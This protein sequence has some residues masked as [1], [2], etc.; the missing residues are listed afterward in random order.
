MLKKLLFG[1]LLS[2]LLVSCIDNNDTPPKD[3][4]A[5]LTAKLWTFNRFEI[6]ELNEN[7]GKYTEAEVEAIINKLRKGI[8]FKF[9]EDT[10]GTYTVRSESFD[11]NWSLEEGILKLRFSDSMLN[12]DFRLNDV[13]EEELN[14]SF[15]TLSTGIFNNQKTTYRGNHFYR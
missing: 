14:I 7:P 5:L 4:K 10:S 8:T 15:L 12:T 1:V 6:T 9:N 2:F 11:L 13:S 3:E